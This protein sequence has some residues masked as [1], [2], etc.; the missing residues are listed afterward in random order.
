[1]FNTGLFVYGYGKYFEFVVNIFIII[2]VSKIHV[3]YIANIIGK[4]PFFLSIISFKL[5]GC[6]M[7]T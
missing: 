1:M 3:I 7:K 6:M 5:S 2:K 4:L